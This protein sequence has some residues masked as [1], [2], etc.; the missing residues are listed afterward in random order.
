MCHLRL[1]N[2]F[3]FICLECIDRVSYCDAIKN[4]CTDPLIASS[5]EHYCAKTCGV[6]QGKN[7]NDPLLIH[8]E[9]M[10]L[11]RY[12]TTCTFKTIVCFLGFIFIY[13]FIHFTVPTTP[14][15]P[16]TIPRTERPIDQ[17]ELTQ[18]YD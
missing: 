8:S 10:L 7:V 2:N 16:T 13:L 11:F 18:F 15:P 9:E 14:P 3:F 6:C 5:M 1:I 12:I 17:G 4:R